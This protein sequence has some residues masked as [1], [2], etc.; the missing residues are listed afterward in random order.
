MV[1][2]LGDPA[3][4]PGMGWQHEG[5]IVLLVGPFAPSL[6]GSELEKQRGELARG[7]PPVD[8]DAQ[9]R[10]HAAVRALV[11]GGLV[12]SIHDVS[13][14]GVAAALAECSI[15][16]GLGAS[17]NLGALAEQAGGSGEVALFGEGPGGWVV[18]V[19]P[20]GLDRVR[21]EAGPIGIL[22]L[23]RVA[24]DRLVAA[25]SAA[26]LALSVSELRDA[27]ETGVA[28]RLR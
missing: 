15:A 11:A 17:V 18:S 12:S 27:Y 9:A 3:D 23:G 6:A 10:A 7:L 25:A 14:G 8:L 13:D 28:D 1:G 24:G 4:L 20:E 26:S 21:R 2:K 22:E 5:D 19:P 16:S